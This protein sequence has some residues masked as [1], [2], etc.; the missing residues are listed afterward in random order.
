VRGPMLQGERVS[1]E[2]PRGEDMATYLAWNESC[3][4][5]RFLWGRPGIPSL[6]QQH[7]WLERVSR[8]ENEVAWRIAVDDRTVGRTSIFGIDWINRRAETSIVIGEPS[9][10]G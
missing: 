8:A 7:E 1:L 3:E 9:L 2:P 10:W 5:T 6:T 4:F